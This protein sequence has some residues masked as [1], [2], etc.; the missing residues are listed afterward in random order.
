MRLARRMAGF[1]T[2]HAGLTRLTSLASVSLAASGPA[3]LVVV[4]VASHSAASIPLLLQTPRL[5]CHIGS[6]WLCSGI[7]G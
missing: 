6:C 3:H 1:V 7:L 2:G 4:R 5:S